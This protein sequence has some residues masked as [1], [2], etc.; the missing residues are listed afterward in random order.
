MVNHFLIF[1][2][3]PPP[4]LYRIPVKSSIFELNLKKVFYYICLIQRIHNRVK[5][6]VLACKPWKRKSHYSDG[7]VFFK[8]KCWPLFHIIWYCPIDHSGILW[9]VKVQELWIYFN[10]SCIEVAVSEK[11]IKTE[12]MIVWAEPKVC[13]RT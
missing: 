8:I 4:R 3:P 12:L 7:I 2:T 5:L 1:P 9:P 6:G 10:K 13:Q 11:R